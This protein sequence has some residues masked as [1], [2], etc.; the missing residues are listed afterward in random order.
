MKIG[1]TW[2]YKKWLAKSID[3]NLPEYVD[4]DVGNINDGFSTYSIRV[5]ITAIVGHDDDD[6]IFFK[7]V[8]SYDD[9]YSMSRKA[10]LQV[11]EK[12][13]QHESGRNLEA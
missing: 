12:D 11:F 4:V 7:E 5:V 1:E 6:I 10:F 3:D 13:W 2:R 8:S 9:E